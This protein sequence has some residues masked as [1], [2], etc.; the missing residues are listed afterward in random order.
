MIKTYESFTELAD[1]MC[2]GNVVLHLYNC[3]QNREIDPCIAWQ[4]GVRSFAEWLD[5]IGVKVEVPDKVEGFYEFSA[6]KFARTM[7]RVG[8]MK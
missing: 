3:A 7:V 5:H 1:A 6:K 2:D 8:K 4:S